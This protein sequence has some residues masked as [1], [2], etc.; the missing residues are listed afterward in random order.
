LA[1]SYVDNLTLK[2]SSDSEYSNICAV[3]YFVNII[4]KQGANL[5]VV[6][7]IPKTELI[8]WRALEDWSDISFIPIVI[9]DLGFLLSQA[10]RCPSYLLIPSMQTSIHF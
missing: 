7:P 4:Q 6:F 2:V 5:G 10:V 3:Q 8:H 9:N 1:I